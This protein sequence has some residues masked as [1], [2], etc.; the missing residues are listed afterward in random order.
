MRVQLY[1]LCM[2]LSLLACTTGTTDTSNLVAKVYDDELTKDKLEEVIPNHLTGNDSIKLSTAYIQ[3]WALEKLL[4]KNALVNL[5]NTDKLDALVGKYK[6]DLYVDYYK[7]ALVKK[8]L[9]TLVLNDEIEKFYKQNKES[10]KLK[11]TLIKFRYIKV[12]SDSKNNDAIVKLLG[13]D[14]LEDKEELLKKYHDFGEF[15]F[16]DSTWVSLDGV[17][18]SKSDFPVLAHQE[19]QLKNR[20]LKKKSKKGDMYY[21]VLKEVLNPN[22]LAPLPYVH[23]TIKEILLHKNKLKFFNK[24]EQVL[25][26]DAVKQNKYEIYP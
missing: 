5:D 25:I 9:D 19:L 13:T 11:E 22:E 4:Y 21:V 16:S 26:D 8:K 14:V 1:S 15:Y 18:K 2:V 6:Q 7:N 24:M 12:D 20:V 3:N 17:Y 10:F 23:E